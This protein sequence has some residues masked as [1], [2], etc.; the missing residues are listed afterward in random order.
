[1]EL[2]W[3]KR[4]EANSVPET[5]RPVHGALKRPEATRDNPEARPHFKA[6]YEVDEIARRSRGAA[7]GPRQGQCAQL[8]KIDNFLPSRPGRWYCFSERPTSGARTPHGRRATLASASRVDSD[9]G[10]APQTI[11]IAQNGLGRPH[12]AGNHPRRSGGTASLASASSASSTPIAACA[13]E[14]RR[15][16]DTVFSLASLRPRA[17]RTGT[18]AK[19]C[20]RTL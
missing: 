15:R 4:K 2:L 13:L 11:E 14:P 12:P 8:R 18:F 6:C 3:A 9:S 17:M 7:N 19:E 20:S 5:G 16:T 10:M 1:M